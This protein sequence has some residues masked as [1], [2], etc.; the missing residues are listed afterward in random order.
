M[1]QNAKTLGPCRTCGDYGSLTMQHVR[2]VP[3]LESFK[4]PLCQNCHLVVTRYEDEI[5]RAIDHVR[6][7]PELNLE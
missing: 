2:L 5:T 3:E 4:I 6:E 7:E 1:T